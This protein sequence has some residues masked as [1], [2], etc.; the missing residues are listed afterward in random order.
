MS[1]KND[2]PAGMNL[3]VDLHWRANEAKT[4]YL[5]EL[6]GLIYREMKDDIEAVWDLLESPI[7]EVAIFY[8][9]A[10]NYAYGDD[11]PPIYLKVARERG[12][13]SHFHYPVQLIPQV[14][15][16]PYRV[17]FLYDC[18]GRLLAVECDGADF[19]QD[20]KRD[21]FRDAHLKKHYGVSVL[22][23]RGKDIWKNNKAAAMVASVIQAWML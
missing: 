14:T 2:K 16:G 4:D 20:V 5:G 12:L 9:A 3:G 10:I 21:E 19:H 17:D 1:D 23:V 13:H 7:E 11:R 6:P 22:R 18:R 15:F 8:L